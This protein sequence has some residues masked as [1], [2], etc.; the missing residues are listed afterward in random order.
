MDNIYS[1]DIHFK[2]FTSNDTYDLEQVVDFWIAYESPRI[3][4]TRISNCMCVKN[5]EIIYEYC[6][7][8]LYNENLSPNESGEE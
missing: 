7:S 6:L 3:L 4:E 5:N 2:V 8:V 1:D